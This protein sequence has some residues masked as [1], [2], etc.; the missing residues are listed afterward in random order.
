MFN[1]LTLTLLGGYRKFTKY[2]FLNV[3]L[4]TADEFS[5]VMPSLEGFVVNSGL[6]SDVGQ[7]K[8][9]ELNI[10]VVSS[11]IL[12]VNHFSTFHLLRHF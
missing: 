5:L 9:V 2:L 11:K 10:D 8:V 6:N 7:E 4:F 12:S 3:R 1:L